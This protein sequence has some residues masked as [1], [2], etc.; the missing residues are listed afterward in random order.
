VNERGSQ[1]PS[2]PTSSTGRIDQLCD[3][4][5]RACQ[6]G[7][8]PLIE[9]YLMQAPAGDRDRL[10]G[11]LLEIE[12]DF[13]QR[14]GAF[15]QLEEYRNRFPESARLVESVFRRAVKT[16]RLGDYELLE[17]LGRG[18]MGVV[19]RARQIYLNQFVALKILPH[20]YLDDSQA[21]SRF[22]REMQ[23]IGALN[24]PNIVR[25]F[26]AGEAGGVHFLV[27]EYVDGVNLQ[28]F[29]SAAVPP[30]G[31]LAVG[32]A[33]EVIR[34]A[35][36]GL[37]HAHEHQLVHRD[38][39]PANL[40]LS[41]SGEVKLLD[42]GLAKLQAEWRGEN[43]PGGLTQ[44]GMTMGT[45]DYMAPEQWE[46]SATAD[47]RADIYSLGCTLFFLLT[48][49]TPYGDPAYDTG[50]KKL[51]AHAVAPIP[52]LL[53]RCPDCPHDLA[54]VYE[55]MLAKNPKDRY[56]D[57]AEVVEALAEFADAEELAQVIA[58]IPADDAWMA[59]G[60]PGLNSPEADTAKPQGAASVGSNALRRT[61]GRRTAREKRRRT[62][63]MVLIGSAAAAVCGLMIWGLTRPSDVVK[64]KTDS[65][66]NVPVT[67]GP[68]YSRKA[69]AADLALLP[70]L[71]GPWWFEE[72]PWLTPPLR[73]AIAG[74]VLGLTARQELPADFSQPGKPDLLSAADLA[75]VLGERPVRYFSSNT[76]DVQKWLWEAAGRCRETL[77]PAQSQLVDQ[78]K[79]FA[80]ASYDDDRTAA[81]AMENCLQQFLASHGSG[82]WS[83]VDL[84]T[85]ALLQ[86]RIAV[87]RSDESMAAEAKKSYAL[88]L[89]AYAAGKA[90]PASTRLLCLT[91]EAV[92]SAGLWP[93]WNDTKR[94]LDAVLAERDLPVLF[95]AS[96]L[97]AR[98]DA[99]EVSATSASDY[100]DHQ[101]LHAARV[102]GSA[103]S[104]RHNHPLAAYIAER[105]GW[106]LI[107]QWKVEEASRQFQDATTIRT[108]NKKAGNPSAAIYVFHDHHGSALADR[109][110]GNLGSARRTFMSIVDEVKADLE[111]A[112]GRHKVAENSG[113]V[114]ALR[115]RLSNS[116]ERLADCEFYGGA[117]SGGRVNLAT[118]AENYESARTT[119]DDR[120]DATAIAAKQ[121]IVLALNGRTAAAEE[122]LR[123]LDSDKRPVLGKSVER[124]AL[125]R[126][127]AHAVIAAKGEHPANGHKLLRAF[128]DQFKLNPVYR[129]TSRRETMELQLFAAELLVAADLENEPAMA[130]RDQKYLDALLAVFQGRRDI[131]P[132]LRRYYELAIRACNKDN[133]AQIAHYLIGS[134]MDEQK[135]ALD[136][137]A[138]LVLFSFMPKENIALFLPQDGRPGK[139]F[140]LEITREQI[141]QAK[142]QP[143]H[144]NDELVA[145]IKTEKSAGRSVEIFWDDTA[146]RPVGDADALSD[147]DW[148]FAPQLELTRVPAT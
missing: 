3:Q 101:Y 39:K 98:G 138:T 116:R 118:A 42:M 115:E 111:T 88:A 74:K 10:L 97:V 147:R 81:N 65:S 78:L 21:V 6:A 11:E 40:M 60:K 53:D 32:A 143:L 95:R 51:M 79:A 76:H 44:P 145:L 58:S 103:E 20:R 15:L 19:Y 54:A 18:G 7:Q 108:E 22:R 12:L 94:Q 57:P 29:V 86:H 67:S 139:R 73:E 80:D 85:K 131:R 133:L 106:S 105:Y 120:S 132:Y 82:A 110:R 25:A 92:F 8:P 1:E 112:Q 77:T 37:Q 113:C 102:L 107:D 16:R 24:H 140:A 36:L 127:L 38:V 4:F 83:E 96:A 72:M 45:I 56:A 9:E 35:A 119:A 136:S 66:G 91:D 144:L 123:A 141:K 23:S 55:T 64:N 93:N 128:L 62:I 84:H 87:L 124:A 99:A 5:E 2:S 71:N 63:K 49:K 117:A 126:Q 70:G 34:Q 142:N 13:R 30:G 46:N 148:P 28:Q 31:P 33:C 137:P 17:E 41:R 130:N 52:P 90:T 134:R 135:G 104:I 125:A 129:D 146:S 14:G 43:Q 48:G 114:R 89:D 61:L 122:I 100:E 27:M 75:P 50:R 68:R 121:A 26:N 47:I 109:Y 59:A 69:I